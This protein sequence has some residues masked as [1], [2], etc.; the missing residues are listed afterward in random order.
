MGNASKV[1]VK[2]EMPR[3]LRQAKQGFDQWRRTRR[4]GQAIPDELWAVAAQA[5]SELG[6][7]RAS[8]ALR[9]NHTA[10]QSEVRKRAGA[11]ATEQEAVPQFVS[12][13]LPASGAGPEWIIEAEN[14]RGVRL[15]I[16]LKGCSTS[17]LVSLTGAL[18]G[19]EP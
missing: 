18:W 14:G 7:N 3:T 16:Q 9:L 2:R 5:A 4:G 13:A 8:R 19:T 15:R 10:L 12:L 1:G 17:D 6:V 11:V